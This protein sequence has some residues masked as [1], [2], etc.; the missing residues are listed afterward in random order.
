MVIIET[1]H[2]GDVYTTVV[3]LGCHLR[4]E[5]NYK[6]SEGVCLPRNAIYSH[7]LDFCERE[8]HTPVNAAR[9]GKI[10][11]QK[12]P[13]LSTRRLGTRG[14]SKYHYFGLAIKESSVYFGTVQPY[15]KPGTVAES[16]KKDSGNKDKSVSEI[17]L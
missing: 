12:F 16:S 5:E 3:V 17:L 15:R 11:R 1:V 4:L 7:Y 13:S 6:L 9:F 14:Q 8:G 2:G 10:V